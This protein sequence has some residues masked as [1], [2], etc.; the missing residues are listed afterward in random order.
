M[1]SAIQN[2]SDMMQINSILMVALAVLGI[3]LFFLGVAVCFAIIQINKSL[4]DIRDVYLEYGKA[5]KISPQ[6]QI[7][8]RGNSDSPNQ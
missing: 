1:Y 6:P 7:D 4:Q 3:F 8:S 2:S 5:Q